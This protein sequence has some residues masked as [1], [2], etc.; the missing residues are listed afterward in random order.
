MLGY[1]DYPYS[2]PEQLTGDYIIATYLVYG[3]DSSN[4][5]KKIG[6]FAVGQ[7]IGTWIRI[8]GVTQEMVENYQGRILS[9]H[10]I[11]SGEETIV[12]LRLAFP[13]ANFA[14]N[15]SMMLTAM[16]G[17][18]VSTA[19]RTKLIDIELAGNAIGAFRGPSQ[20]IDDLRKLTKAFGRPL[21][22][23]M[24][25]PCTGFSPVEGAKL[26]YEAALGGIDLIKDDE[27]L[28]NTGY[29]EVADRVREYTKAAK[30]AAEHTG[31]ETVYLVNITDSPSKMKDNAKAAIQ[32]GAKGCLVNFVFGGIDSMAEICG[33]FGDKLFI[34]AHYAGVGVMNWQKG[35][36]ANSVYIGLIPRLAGAHAVMTMFVGENNAD[37]RYDFFK[38]IQSQRM[39]IGEIK[40]VVTA[41]G[42]G[43]TPLNLAGIYDDIGK[44]IILGVGGAVQGHPNGAACGAKAT[45]SAVKAAVEGIPIEQAAKECEHLKAAVDCW[46]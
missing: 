11:P 10:Q 29:N 39:A 43:I 46:G 19:L 31:K 23:N 9:M 37:D 21:V 2:R 35:G 18:D 12:V 25:K 15:F 44:D 45:M 32:S 14:G 26:F 8:P 4:V 16:M 34:M 40:P 28:G 13:I 1:F 42:G 5:F 6:N 33:E 30:S 3:T 27:L 36:I 7:T 20:S 38:T 41:V 22:L 24:I 17:N